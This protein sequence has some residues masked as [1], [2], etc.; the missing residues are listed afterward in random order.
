MQGALPQLTETTRFERLEGLRRDLLAELSDPVN[1]KW[2]LIALA[3][4]VVAGAVLYPLWRVARFQ[5]RRFAWVNQMRRMGL[6]EDEVALFAEISSHAPSRVLAAHRLDPYAYDRAVRAFL[7]RRTTP[8]DRNRS[9]LNAIALRTRLPLADEVALPSP[10]PGDR[11]SVRFRG[12]D[13]PGVIAADV[14]AVQRNAMKLALLE[15]L[16]PGQLTPGGLVR[17]RARLREATAEAPAL[18]RSRINGTQPRIYVSTVAPF[19]RGRHVIRS[20]AIDVAASLVLVERLTPGKAEAKA[21][22]LE[23]RVTRDCSLGLYVALKRGRLEIGEAARVRA[24]A[25]S[26]DHVVY[27]ELATG[28]GQTQY[29]LMRTGY[30]AAEPAAPTPVAAAAR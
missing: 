26:G 30:R 5:K 13:G 1:A 29:F 23:C 11:I 22:V 20:K 18:V 7:R 15:R 21:P 16:R 9:M 12:D 17:L 27:D 6:D 19:L 28:G 2:G 14:V 3:V 10:Q 8:A 4:V 25:L 24:D